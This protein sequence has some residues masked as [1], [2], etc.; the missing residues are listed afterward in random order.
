MN[1]RFLITGCSGG[2]KST[3]LNHLEALG[4][5]V[6][7][8]P[9]LRVIHGGGPA[10]WEDRLG[11]FEA[12]TAISLADLDEPVAHDTPTF[13]DRGLFDALSGRA[14]R[15]RVPVGDL[16]PTPFPY[17][18]PVFYAPPWPEIYEETEDRRHSF[19]M[20]EDEALRLRRDLIALDLKVIE[21]PKVSV[22]ERAEIV[23]RA[24]L[25][26]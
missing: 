8:E 7:H 17:A 22:A 26:T 19:A 24:A 12:V 1:Q 14:G 25:S 23:L 20:A 6:V 5:A 3:L 18:Q 4:H 15:E 10:P 2:G 9:G 11:F 21:L 13:F 16:M